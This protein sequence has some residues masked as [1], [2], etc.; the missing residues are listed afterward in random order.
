[1]F[2]R[3]SVRLKFTTLF[4]LL[5]FVAGDASAMQIFVKTLTGKTVILEVEGTDTIEAVKAKLQ[6][7]EGIPPDQQRLIFAGKQLEDGRTLQDYNIQKESTLHLVLRLRGGEVTVEVL[8]EMAHPYSALKSNNVSLVNSYIKNVLSSSHKSCATQGVEIFEGKACI[9]GNYWYSSRYVFGDSDRNGY[10]SLTAA[11]IYGLDYRLTEAISIG[12]RYGTGTGSMD[13]DTNTTGTESQAFVISNHWGLNT[14]YEGGGNTF[15]SGYFGFTDFDVDLDRQSASGSGPST[16][17]SSSFDADAY[18][19]GLKILKIIP[20]ESNVILIPEVSAAFSAYEQPEV[21]EAGSGDLLIVDR[22]SSQ[23]LPMRIGGKALRLLN[24][25]KDHHVANIYLGAWYEFDPYSTRDD[26]R[27][28]SAQSAEG[29]V[30]R[31]VSKS[32][33]L[34]AQKFNVEVGSALKVSEH[35]QVS[36]SGGFGFADS[37]SSS[38]VKSGIVWSF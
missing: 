37:S 9:H 33:A 36:L 15:V 7:K 27:S 5:F 21:V 12:L 6:D 28:I 31:A 8:K 13:N 26:D 32:Q 20:V 35:F 19:L 22:S 16:S 14:T 24:F 4:L 30:V 34:S 1:M 10:Q 25:S 38:Y 17:A 23:S 3:I 29:A 11:G 2:G 18:S